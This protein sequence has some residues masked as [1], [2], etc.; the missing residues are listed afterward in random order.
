VSEA[1]RGELRG[2][3]VDVSCVMPGI[4]NTELAQGLHQARGVKNIDP[5]DVANAIVEV[6]KVPRFDVYVPKSIGP[7]SKFMGL[8][9]RAGR[10]AVVRALKAD[11]VLQVDPADRRGYEL[12]AARSEPGLESGDA[13]RELTT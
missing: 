3:N 6:L 9:P 11:T 13:Q 2:T 10:E 4:V 7:I 8:L 12:R 5:T 1:V